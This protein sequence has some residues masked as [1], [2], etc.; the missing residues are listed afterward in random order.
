MVSKGTFF[1]LSDCIFSNFLYN[2]PNFFLFISNFLQ[3]FLKEFRSSSSYFF[4]FLMNTFKDYSSDHFRHLFRVFFHHSFSIS[5]RISAS[6]ISRDSWTNFSRI[7][8][9]KSVPPI[10]FSGTILIFFFKYPTISSNYFHNLILEHIY[11]VFTLGGLLKIPTEILPQKNTQ[12]FI[13]ELKR[14]VQGLYP[15]TLHEC[16][17]LSM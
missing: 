5:F 1:P 15:E 17:R 8:F 12:R 10:I 4:W 13:P 7:W 14:I 2:H 9:R 3:S 11:P 6:D 16:V